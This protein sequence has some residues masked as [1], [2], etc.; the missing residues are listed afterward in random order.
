MDVHGL[1]WQLVIIFSKTIIEVIILIIKKSRED[2]EKLIKNRTK[3]G[4]ICLK[5]RKQNFKIRL[6]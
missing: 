2:E 6:S 4:G 1:P 5:G 3:S